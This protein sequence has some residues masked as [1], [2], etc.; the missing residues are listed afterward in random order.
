MRQQTMIERIAQ[1]IADDA[2]DGRDYSVVARN[3]LQ[4]IREPTNGM[5]K[6]W[7]GN[8]YPDLEDEDSVEHL[9]FYQC[10]ID[11]AIEEVPE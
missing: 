7:S 6:G 1:V 2:G 11:A 3:V 8:P 4:A 10:M 5:W 9:R